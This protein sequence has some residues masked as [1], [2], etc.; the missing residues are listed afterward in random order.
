MAFLLQSKD[1]NA[2]LIRIVLLTVSDKLTDDQIKASH[3][4][5]FF[6][7]LAEM[8]TMILWIALLGAKNLTTNLKKCT[9]RQTNQIADA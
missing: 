6:S 9:Q 3:D 5:F 7:Y 2:N 1:K 8:R 4:T